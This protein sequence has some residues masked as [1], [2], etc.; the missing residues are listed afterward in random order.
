M[1]NHASSERLSAAPS[2]SS[3]PAVRLYGRLEGE[4]PATDKGKGRADPLQSTL[5]PSLLTPSPPATPLS[6]AIEEAIST[7]LFAS[8]SLVSSFEQK[9]P[10]VLPPQAHHANPSR[11]FAYPR[12]LSQLS[13]STLP[14]A[15]LTFAKSGSGPRHGRIASNAVYP[16]QGESSKSRHRDATSS[17]LTYDAFPDL[18]PTTGLPLAA[19][20]GSDDVFNPS[21]H[22]QR[23]ITDVIHAPPQPEDFKPSFLPGIPTLPFAMPRMKLGRSKSSLDLTRSNSSRN[24]STSAPNEDW[25]SWA[26]GWWG[27]NKGKVDRMMDEDDRADTVEEER[28]KHRQKCKFPDVMAAADIIRPEPKAPHG[29]LPW[30]SWF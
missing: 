10:I 27:G 18:D 6:S 19:G 17:A 24:L 25:T 20:S 7:P 12:L 1:S 16:Q 22:L 28:E 21:R 2:S 29:L 9:S 23:T 14:T 30:S 8:S 4:G 3:Q 15:S 11:S 5:R 26:T 13:R